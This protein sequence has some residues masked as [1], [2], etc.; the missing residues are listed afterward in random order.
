M[1][2]KISARRNLKRY[3]VFFF[4]FSFE[5]LSWFQILPFCDFLWFG[6]LRTD[7]SLWLSFLKFMNFTRNFKEMAITAIALRENKKE[8]VFFCPWIQFDNKKMSRGQD[9]DRTRRDIQSIWMRLSITGSSYQTPV[10]KHPLAINPSQLQR[11]SKTI[12]LHDL[13][14]LSF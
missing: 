2:R 3:S 7:E 5:L 10:T 4:F 14:R 1:F 8:S 6:K 9:L 11:A 13:A 12:R